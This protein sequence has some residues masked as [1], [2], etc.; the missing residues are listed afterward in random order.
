MFLFFVRDCDVRFR[1]NIAVPINRA[2]DSLKCAS[3]KGV[4]LCDADAPLFVFVRILLGKIC[5]YEYFFSLH[6]SLKKTDLKSGKYVN[7]LNPLFFKL[8][9]FPTPNED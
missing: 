8:C 2:F 5:D 7:F 4:T 9:S 1:I 3:D 6:S